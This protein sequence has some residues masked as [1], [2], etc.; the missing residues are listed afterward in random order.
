MCGS[1]K[2][3]KN[4]RENDLLKSLNLLKKIKVEQRQTLQCLMGGDGTQGS[5][6]VGRGYQG[7]SWKIKE[8]YATLP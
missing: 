1:E 8:E 3:K 4:V 5:G 6:G 7:E 2:A